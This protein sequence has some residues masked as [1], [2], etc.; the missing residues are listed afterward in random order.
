MKLEVK[1]AS[2]NDNPSDVGMSVFD[3]KGNLRPAEAQEVELGLRPGGAMAGLAGGAE[4]SYV[5]GGMIGPPGGIS[6]AGL[7]RLYSIVGRP[8][9]ERDAAKLGL[10]GGD[11]HGGA[12]L[13]ETLGA[14]L[15]GI[16]QLL[17]IAKGWAARASRDSGSKI[18]GRRTLRRM[19]RRLQQAQDEQSAA[20]GEIEYLRRRVVQLEAEASRWREV[21]GR[22]AAES[23]A[24]GR[25]MQAVAAGMPLHEARKAA[26]A[27]LAFLPPPAPVLDDHLRRQRQSRMN[28][29]PS[30]VTASS[31]ASPGAYS[32]LRRAQGTSLAV[33]EG[34][35]L[36]ANHLREVR[37]VGKPNKA[38]IAQGATRR[39]EIPMHEPSSPKRM[40]PTDDRV[41]DVEAEHDEH[42]GDGSGAA[43]AAPDAAEDR[44]LPAFYETLYSSS[45]PSSGDDATQMSSRLAQAASM[46]ASSGVD[47][48]NDSGLMGGMAGAGDESSWMM[49][50]GRPYGLQFQERARS[51]HGPPGS[52]MRPARH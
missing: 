32:P 52:P 4:E 38:G 24:I 22:R 16:R 17:A 27:R 9:L 31:P 45:G 48:S 51:H 23:H 19:S 33:L 20:S 41:S 44:P 50:S 14:G 7:G 13:L 2:P 26:Q 39:R 25:Q 30:V 49:A 5:R 47:T 34:R 11:G 21:A 12:G 6:L 1:W 37:R 42:R 40:D 43:D 36:V 35:D 46:A 28:T 15:V 29:K 3:G 18:E 10:V 8:A